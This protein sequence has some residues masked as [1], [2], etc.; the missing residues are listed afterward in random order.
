M[1]ELN[2]I[3]IQQVQGGVELAFLLS[4]V[5]GAKGYSESNTIKNC[6]IYGAVVGGIVG[7]PLFIVGALVT[8]PIGAVVGALEGW[9]GYEIGSLFYDG[10]VHR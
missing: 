10:P 9:I 4:I 1:K 7:L 2:Q 8:A 3:E 6:A 5:S